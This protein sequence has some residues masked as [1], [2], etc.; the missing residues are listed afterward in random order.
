MAIIVRVGKTF[1][2]VVCFTFFGASTFQAESIVVNVNLL[3][4]LKLKICSETQLTVYTGKI[5]RC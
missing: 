5:Y 1:P 3:K 4:I 2:R